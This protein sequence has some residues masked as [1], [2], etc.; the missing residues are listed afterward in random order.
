V[1]EEKDGTYK[2]EVE[3]WKNAPEIE[4]AFKPLRRTGRERRNGNEAGEG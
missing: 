3:G 2:P 1:R 4:T